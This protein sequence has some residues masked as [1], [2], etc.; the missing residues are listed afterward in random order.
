MKPVTGILLGE[1]IFY[2]LYYNSI[3]AFGCNAK[4]FVIAF[5]F[6]SLFAFVCNAKSFAIVCLI[7]ILH[8]LF[9]VSVFGWTTNIFLENILTLF[10]TEVCDQDLTHSWH[11]SKNISVKIIPQIV[12]WHMTRLIHGNL[13]SQHPK[14]HKKQ[15]ETRKQ[16]K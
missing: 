8:S 10:T 7:Y 11:R 14:E 4:R 16:V 1:K 15:L 12:T 6:L 2:S 9:L 3:T 5:L 13:H